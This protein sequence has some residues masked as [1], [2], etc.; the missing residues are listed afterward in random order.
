[1]YLWTSLVTVAELLALWS[2]R[3]AVK[4]TMGQADHL[5]AT[6]GGGY[7]QQ[8]QQY[9]VKNTDHQ[10]LRHLFRRWIYLAIIFSSA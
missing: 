7:R 10:Q 1:M 5:Y 3:I 8:Q 9:S 2:D 4:L 6:G